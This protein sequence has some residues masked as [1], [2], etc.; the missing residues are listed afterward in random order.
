MG[1]FLQ[2]LIQRLAN[3]AGYQIVSLANFYGFQSRSPERLLDT[4]KEL[5]EVYKE[6]VFSKFPVHDSKRV[7]LYSKLAGTQ[8]SSAIYLVNHLHK[9]LN[10]PGDVC[11]FGV[12]QGRTS[13]LIANEIQSSSKKLWLFDSFQGLPKPSE[14]DILTDDVFDLGSMGAYEGTM[15]FPIRV[16]KEALAEVD[17][18]EDRIR[19]VPGFIEAT[20]KSSEVP[21]RVCFA[22]VDLDFYE[23]I[24]T[25]LR[26]L[27]EVIVPE[28][29]IVIDDYGWFSAGA[30]LAVDEFFESHRSSYALFSPIKS[31]GH[32]VILQ[33]L[34]QI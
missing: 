33:R 3:S 16:L 24:L 4:I 6:L 7:D 21:D 34:E 13:V 32:F 15:S 1:G 12:A 10:L 2:A 11:E 9:S 23:P 8:V 14:K 29:F 31:A 25:T 17:L 20:L 22:Y 26:F 19:I 18:A 28:G 30:K 27:H 5:E